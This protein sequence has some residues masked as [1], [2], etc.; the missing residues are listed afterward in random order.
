MRKEKRTEK[1]FPS[2]ERHTEGLPDKINF[3]RSEKKT[4]RI[5][6]KIRPPKTLLMVKTL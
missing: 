1:R 6:F 5:P 4:Q 3:R 2:E